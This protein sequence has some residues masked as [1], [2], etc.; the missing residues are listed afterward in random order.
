MLHNVGKIAI[1][2][3]ILFKPGKLDPQERRL[4]EKHCSFGKDI[5][6]PIGEQ[7]LQKLRAHTRL[8]ADILHVRSSPMMLM[9]ARIAQTHHEKW[10]GSGYP[11]GL[12]KEDI[13]IE[14]RITAVADVF[15]A[16][17][18]KRS[19]KKAFPCEKC[20]KIIVDGR[21]SHFDP[22]VVDAFLARSQDI[23]QV[24]MDLMDRQT[25]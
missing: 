3:S 21:G 10:D 24:Q 11:I 15:Y 25:R 20:F 19:Y 23:V 5:I 1:P 17:S 7:D 18:S 22:Q 6:E 9:A 14:A 8:G 12:A 4:I 16:L 2:D 13:P